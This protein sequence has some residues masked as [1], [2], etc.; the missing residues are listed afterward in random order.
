M[1]ADEESVYPSGVSPRKSG[2]KVPNGWQVFV[3]ERRGGGERGGRREGEGGREGGRKSANENERESDSGKKG[4][5]R[6][7][8]TERE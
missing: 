7:R 8:N 6:Q 2:A 1:L 3:R 5:D 4:R